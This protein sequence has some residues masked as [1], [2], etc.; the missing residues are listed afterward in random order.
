MASTRQA[1]SSPR[2]IRVGIGGWKYAPW[3]DNF[4]PSGL[5][6][7]DELHYA[8]RHVTAI[9]INST[10]Y[11]AQKPATFAAWRDA[12]PDDFLFSVKAPR[13]VTHRRELA[14]AADAV[15]R[16]IDG[17]IAE[18]G[19][20]LGPL[21]WQ[22]PPG[23]AFDSAD[24]EAFLQLLPARIGTR[25]LRHVLEVRH[26][27]FM[28]AE[29]LAMARRFGCATVYTDSPKYPSFAD[30]TGPFVYARL[31]RSSA[32]LRAGYAPRALDAWRERALEWS[33]GGA[34]ADLPRIEQEPPPAAARDV[35]VYF[36]NGA[37]ERAPAAAAALLSR[38]AG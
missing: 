8:S 36:I 20:K 37:K 3:R 31:M 24:F 28:T 9:E 7:A 17:G 1:S 23:K 16:F 34:P 29:Y 11:G 30:L 33:A 21:L 10:F 27:S 12:T 15:A 35:F 26:A 18:L 22:F 19:A 25:T 38:L 14:T 6:Q 2:S 4:Y 13:L 32:R 5:P